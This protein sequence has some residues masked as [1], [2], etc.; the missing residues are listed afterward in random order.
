MSYLQAEVVKDRANNQANGMQTCGVGEHRGGETPE[1]GGLRFQ[2]SDFP[3]VGGIST[4]PAGSRL[5][6]GPS[7]GG[8]THGT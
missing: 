1:G 3:A 6:A 4:H 2:I 7:V 8:T 5:K